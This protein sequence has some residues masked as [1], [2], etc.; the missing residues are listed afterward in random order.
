[1][2]FSVRQ[3]LREIPV[4]TLKAYFELK[5]AAGPPERWKHKGPKLASELAGYLISGT[6]QIGETILGIW[7]AFTLS[8]PQTQDG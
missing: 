4:R 8:L 6:D 3:F 1:M 2:T 7:S 5:N